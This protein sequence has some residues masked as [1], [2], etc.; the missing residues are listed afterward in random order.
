MGVML[1]FVCPDTGREVPVRILRG[2]EL[3]K[4]LKEHEFTFHC[5]EC[6]RAHA[7]SIGEGELAM[8]EVEPAPIPRTARIP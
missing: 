6:N 4:D 1:T 2:G 5:M 7:W 3:L 8:G